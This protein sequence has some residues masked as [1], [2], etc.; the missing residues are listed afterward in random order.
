[1]PKLPMF[2]L[3]G[4]CLIL[5]I[6]QGI[7]YYIPSG[8]SS[9]STTVDGYSVNYSVDPSAPFQCTE[10]HL[11]NADGP[12]KY[13]VLI[14]DSYRTAIDSNSVAPT[15]YFLKE[16]FDR[17][18]GLSLESKNA[19]EI[20]ALIDSGTHDFGMIVFTGAI[21]EVLYNG[22]MASPLIQWIDNG[23]YLIWSGDMFGRL[24]S[25][26]DGVNE[27][28][29][30]HTLVSTALFGAEYVFNTSGETSYGQQRLNPDLTGAA[31]MYFANTTYGIDT[32]KLTVPNQS[33]GY[34]DGTFSSV[35]VMRIGTGT[36]CCFGDCTLYQD[37]E[38]LAHISLL[39]IEADS[40]LVSESTRDMDRRGISGSFTDSADL[41]SL[42]I[43]H[44]F[45]W[46]KAWMYDRTQQ[47][48]V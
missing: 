29:D 33:L 16:T 12:S 1:M 6:G 32:A 13:Y 22:T 48:F 28:P 47:R 14:D 39:G 44:D 45:R 17:C 21:P 30:Y 4:V 40:E 10:I 23:G 20:K 35:S 26:A 34:T 42:V 43:I 36:L 46:S 8:G 27:V 15:L 2:I 31:G 3:A 19:T 25:T 38:Y 41:R 7:S 9:I 37:A 24:V 11:R 18:P 5:L